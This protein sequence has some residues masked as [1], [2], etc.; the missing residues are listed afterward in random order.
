MSFSFSLA[1]N[2]ITICVSVHTY[3]LFKET[4]N[5]SPSP[6]DDGKQGDGKSLTR[7]Q[8]K[9]YFYIHHYI[10]KLA[11]TNLYIYIRMKETK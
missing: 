5:I 7:R 11:N 1:L 6:M 2:I 4:F 10:N 3:N 8:N 9:T